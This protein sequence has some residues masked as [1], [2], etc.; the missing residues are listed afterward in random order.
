MSLFKRPGSPYWYAEIQV[1]GRRIVRSTGTSTRRV[2]ETF[3]RRLREEAKKE[4]DRLGANASVKGAVLNYTVDQMFGRYW[5]EHGSKLSW[6]HEVEGYAKRIVAIVGHILVTNLTTQDCAYLI[7]TLRNGG[8]GLVALNRFIAVFRG[9]HTMAAKKWGVPTHIIDWKLLKTK[10]P[11]ERVRWLTKDEAARLLAC[12]PPHVALIVE[13]SL[14]T[15]LRKLESLNL[16]WDRVDLANGFVEVI[17]KGK[18]VRR[19]LLSDAALNVLARCPKGGRYVFDRTNLRKHFKA[20]LELGGISNFRFHDLR[21]TNATWLRQRGASLEIVQRAL[22]HSS[23]QVTQRYAHVDDQEVLTASN[24]IETVS[25]TNVVQLTRPAKP[26]FV[27]FITD[28]KMVKIGRST[29]PARRLRT[30]QTGHPKPL[31]LIGTISANRL[32][33]TEA[34]AKFAE[35]RGHGE[36]FVLPSAAL[37]EIEAMC[38]AAKSQHVVGFKPRLTLIV[39]T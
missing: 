3:Q 33:E 16:T 25:P 29:D 23:I 21:H 17:A 32:S 24:R 12:L 28:G 5:I 22:G 38:A 13:W 31:W 39:P 2:A 4:A 15:G 19:I 14:Y 11:H 6:A 20:G 27:Y 10:E 7:E 36:W 1:R 37:K 9:A 8:T 30:I 18:K 34:Q 26:S 35:F